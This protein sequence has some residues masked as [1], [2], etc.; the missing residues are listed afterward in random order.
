MDFSF[1]PSEEKMRMEL[2]QWLEQ[3]LPEGWLEGKTD[4]PED[5]YERAEFLRQWQRTLYEG[6]WA[7]ISWPK[8]YGGRGA[9]LMEEVVYEQEMARVKAPP[10]LNVIGIYMV[11]PTLLQI[12]TEEQRR[13]YVPKIL[14]GEEIWCQGYSEPNAGS[15]LASIQTR[16]ERKNGKWV[17]NGQ[18]IWTSYAHVADRCF[19][20]ARTDNTGK[21]HEGIT[22]F[23]VDMHQPGVET[24]PIH[25]MNDQRDFNEVYFND[26]EVDDADVVGEV[27]DGW[28]VGLI[29]LS[30]ERVGIARWVFRLQGQ[31][32]ELVAMTKKL[33]RHGRPLIEDP[34]VRQQLMSFYARTKAALFTYYR[35]L[36]KQQKTGYPGPEGSMDKLVSGTLIQE[37]TAYAVSL[38]GA[39]GPLWKEDAVDDISWQNAFLRAFGHTIEGGTSEIQKN[40][41]AERI[42]GLPKDIKF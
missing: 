42:L 4:L 29:L 25:Q 13:K 7:G 18:K 33:E 5:P 23:L 27:G 36:T 38:Q 41:V 12:G 26:V 40:I 16:A 20:L 32:E 19:L 34:F 15:D 39:Y 1:S 22:A 35:H 10:V 28:R 2:R 31:F 14:S 11:G 8:E 3:H 17:I 6:G 24:R 37:M 21:K 30:H 9:T